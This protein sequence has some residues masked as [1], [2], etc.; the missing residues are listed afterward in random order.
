MDSTFKDLVDNVGENVEIDQT[1]DL[2]EKFFHRYF[3][4]EVQL[5]D[6]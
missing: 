6:Q 2:I 4:L 5:V 3:S 1:V